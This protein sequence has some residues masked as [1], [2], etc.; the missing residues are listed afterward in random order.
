MIEIPDEIWEHMQKLSSIGERK[1]YKAHRI[2]KKGGGYRR[3]YEPIEELKQVQTF[4]LVKVLN[5]VPV[6]E[7]AHGFVKGRSIVSNAHPHINKDIVINMDI[8]E[9]FPSIKTDSVKQIFERYCQ[10]TPEQVEL[11][12]KLCTKKGSLPQGAPTSPAI[13]NIYCIELDKDIVDQLNT[14]KKGAYTRYADDITISANMDSGF[15]P[16]GAMK[17]VEQ[18]VQQHELEMHHGKTNVALRNQRQIVTGILVN[19]RLSLPRET[20]KK[21]RAAIHNAEV[22]GWHNVYWDNKPTPIESVQGMKA[23]MSMVENAN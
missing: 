15:Y 23:L 22:N 6:S 8:R 11:F 19:K 1:L 21:L 13:S 5:N 2:P 16:E 3:I 14:V 20:R 17:M 7:W 18:L 12:T 4:I 10:C 9:F